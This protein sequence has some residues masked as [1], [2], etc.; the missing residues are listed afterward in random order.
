MD[1]KKLKITPLNIILMA[2]FLIF[3]GSMQHQHGLGFVEIAISLASIG[4]SFLIMTVGNPKIYEPLDINKMTLEHKCLYFVLGIAMVLAINFT[5]IQ[6]D[7]SIWTRILSS[8]AMILI[9]IIY[10]IFLRRSSSR[11]QENQ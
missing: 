8:L 11:K 7:I 2:I 5:I 1:W 3:I 6:T 9:A 4:I 10:R